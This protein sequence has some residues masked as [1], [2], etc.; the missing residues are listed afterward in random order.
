[1]QDTAG[2]LDDAG[3]RKASDLVRAMRRAA[4][5]LRSKEIEAGVDADGLAERYGIELIGS[6]APSAQNL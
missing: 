3:R 2:G 4:A 5:E 1:M 6:T